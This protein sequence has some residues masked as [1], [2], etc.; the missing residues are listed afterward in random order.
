MGSCNYYL[1]PLPEY[2]TKKSIL[3]DV[4]VPEVHEFMA[5][6]EF[7]STY[8]A[9]TIGAYVGRHF[10]E[11]KV[12]RGEIGLQRHLRYYMPLDENE[13]IVVVL[14]AKTDKEGKITGFRY[15]IGNGIHFFYGRLP[16][17][18]Y[19]FAISVYRN[20]REN[21]TRIVVHSKGKYL[22][23]DK[24]EPYTVFFA[25]F[26][27]ISQFL[28]FF[29]THK[30]EK[31]DV[32]RAKLYP[33]WIELKIRY[34]ERKELNVVRLIRH[35][36]L[37][38]PNHE[39]QSIRL[40][41]NPSKPATFYLAKANIVHPFWEDQRFYIKSYRIKGY[42]HPAKRLEDHPC[43]EVKTYWKENKDLLT[44]EKFRE[45]V[46]EDV[47]KARCFLNE[48]A[49]MGLDLER[50]LLPL[51]QN[52][53]KPYGKLWKEDRTL[54]KTLNQ[55]CSNPP[56]RREEIEDRKSL[57][58]LLNLGLA[59]EV[60]FNGLKFYQASIPS[61]DSEIATLLKLHSDEVKPDYTIL[62][63]IARDELTLKALEQILKRPVTVPLLSRLFNVVRDKVR[64][65][66]E[67]LV[68]EGI[69]KRY[70]GGRRE[71]FYTFASESIRLKILKIFSALGFKFD[72]E[73]VLTEKFFD[74]LKKA[75]AKLV[76]ALGS[77]LKNYG[78]LLPIK[79]QIILQGLK[80][81]NDKVKDKIMKFVMEKLE[82]K[83]YVT[84]KEIME[85]DLIP[86]KKI[87]DVMEE[88]AKSLDLVERRNGD[89]R[90]FLATYTKKGFAIVECIKDGEWFRV[91][92]RLRWELK[93][94]IVGVS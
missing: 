50:D 43:I 21:V 52:S 87:R 23:Y 10:N 19:K 82:E 90:R 74:E 64:Y 79:L 51:Y 29:T 17:G 2:P 18:Y 12:K 80:K 47:E 41:E 30:G 4:L 5:L 25:M 68:K 71:I 93:P 56:L 86:V 6:I 1:N 53:E 61:Y 72:Y 75:G 34:H 11:D 31:I 15:I 46:K 67:K 59:E 8:P 57:K 84:F 89:Q 32:S 91:P 35:L 54:C 22:E 92:D 7:D 38:F 42:E 44:D 69:L 49:L 66:L 36:G 81:V 9:N 63:K 37:K 27:E 73:P 60:R 78:E 33:R 45:F 26:N 65:V 48:V 28:R 58:V 94:Q 62:T 40:E 16:D 76:H 70:K 85:L 88:I 3:K 39:D 55:L 77:I 83:G 14:K 20:D 24:E 13:E